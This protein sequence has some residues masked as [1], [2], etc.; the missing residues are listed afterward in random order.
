MLKEKRG[1]LTGIS[2]LLIILSLIGGAGQLYSQEKYPT[3]AIDIICPFAAGG[4]TDIYARFAADSLK[5]KWGVPLNVINKTGGNTVPGNIELYNSKPDGY[6]VMADCNS[7]SSLLEAGMRDRPFKVMDRT[8]IAIIAISQNVFYVPSTS[9]IKSMKDLE[10]EIKKAPEKFTWAS[11]GTGSYTDYGAR[12]FFKAI[13]ADVSKTK[14]VMTRGTGEASSLVAGGH[15]KL[16]IGTAT[17][18][19]AVIKAGTAR[20]VG[21]TGL[22][23]PDYPGVATME[24]Q[25]YPT[26][27]WVYWMGF[28]GPPKLPS[29]VIDKWNEALKEVIKDPEFSSRLIKAGGVPNYLNS[30]Q[31]R[32]YVMKEVEET[33]YLWGLK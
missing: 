18:V 32:D 9:H 11:W 3:T 14:P 12:L 20:A 2:L 17:S 8:F 23:H 21:I 28:S 30:N 7:S 31:A 22:R 24:E 4:A 6:T 16:G 10:V 33:A 19:Y 26:V 13:G 15:V 1:F 25:G 29:Y 5:K 27:N